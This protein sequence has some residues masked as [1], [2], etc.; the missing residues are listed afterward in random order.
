MVRKKK[1]IGDVDNIAYSTMLHDSMNILCKESLNL[2]IIKEVG[3]ISEEAKGHACRHFKMIEENI[4]LNFHIWAIIKH[5][6][7]KVAKFRG[8]LF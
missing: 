3:L 1:M 2:S 8:I 5:V 6:A 4:N 7:V